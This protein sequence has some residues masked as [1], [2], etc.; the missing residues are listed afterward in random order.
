LNYNTRNGECEEQNK[1]Q[2]EKVAV[3]ISPLCRENIWHSESIAVRILT[4]G[5][6]ECEWIVSH[7]GRFTPQKGNP[8]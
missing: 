5:P 6:D 3:P 2:G 7:P 4:T 1:E 8:L